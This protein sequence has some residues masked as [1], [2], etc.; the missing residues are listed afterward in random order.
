[1][2]RA[3]PSLM[4]MLAPL[5]AGCA[6]QASGPGQLAGSDWRFVTIDGEAP[7]SQQAK[8]TFDDER[9]GANVGCNHLGGDWRVENGRLIAGPL[10]Q[11]RMFCE[12]KLSE[13]EQ[14]IGALLVAALEVALSDRQLELRSRGH[15][16]RL[17]RVEP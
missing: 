14:A 7:V 17:E 5:V 3:L 12:G 6:A 9:V 13:Q 2:H 8:L 1:M 16:A 10:M 15:H 4:L 11:T